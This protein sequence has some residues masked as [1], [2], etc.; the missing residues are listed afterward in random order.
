MFI[1]CDMSRKLTTA[2]F[3]A[4][5]LIVHGDRYDYSKVNYIDSK[6]KVTIVC[7]EHGKFT[8]TPANHMQGMGCLKCGLKNAGKYHK[9]DTDSFIA[10]AIDRHGTVYDYRNTVYKGA[11]DKLTVI[12]P[13]HGEFEQ[14]AHVHLRSDPGSACLK[15]SYEKRAELSRMKVNEFI[16]RAQRLHKDNYDYSLVAIDFIDASEKV[17]IVCLIHGKFNQSPINH[18][19]G[20]GCPK[21][22]RDRIAKVLTKSTEKFI[23]DCR[24]LHGEK[25]DYSLVDYKGAFEPVKIV[26]PIDGIFE[27]QPT[28]HLSGTG[29]PKCSRRNQGAPRNLTR[30][31]R[32]DFDDER[33]SFVYIVS[34]D[35]PCSQ[36]RLFKI[37][38][39]TGSRKK[40]VINDIKK[41]GGID[42]AVEQIDFPSSGEAIVFEHLAHEQV[43]TFKFAV[44]SE[45]KFAGHSEVFTRC[46]DLSIVEQ[47][48]S[49]ELFRLG[50]RTVLDA[51]DS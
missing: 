46:P 29:C 39:G 6:T 10:E 34:F 2:D 1:Q 21:C 26:C 4:K 23:E 28:T 42:I 7:K 50:E 15:C 38:S 9:K 17:T 25:Y 41:I 5:S 8:Q 18:L 14:T 45:Y 16:S 35:L 32:G 3:V 12:C 24:V 49:L 31:L 13:K 20:H 37:G 43:K 19:L 22:S 40:T 51:S 44:P 36:Q 47:H 33:E 48:P 27:Q 11:R 30:A